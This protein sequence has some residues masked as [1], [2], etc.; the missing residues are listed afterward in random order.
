MVFVELMTRE[1]AKHVSLA[2]NRLVTY[3]SC[4]NDL[5]LCQVAK[6]TF[7]F[8]AVSS[9]SNFVESDTSHRALIRLRSRNGHQLMFKNITTKLCFKLLSLP[10]L[11]LDVLDST[12]CW[13]EDQHHRSNSSTGSGTGKCWFRKCSYPP[14]TNTE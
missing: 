8:K 4:S 6:K 1:T 5:V 3:Y 9:K 10:V 13:T 12:T 7:S 11:T 2:A 14:S